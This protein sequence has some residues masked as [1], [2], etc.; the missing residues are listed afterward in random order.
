MTQGGDESR[1]TT[2]LCGTLPVM[3]FLRLTVFN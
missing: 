2:E 1:P 3:I